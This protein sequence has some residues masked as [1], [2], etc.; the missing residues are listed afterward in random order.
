MKVEDPKTYYCMSA[1]IIEKSTEEP[2]YAFKGM[3]ERV[4]VLERRKCIEKYEVCL[5]QFLQ[6]ESLLVDL[7]QKLIELRVTSEEINTLKVEVEKRKSKSLVIYVVVKYQIFK[8]YF[9]FF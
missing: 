4:L 2:N 1:D 9:K 3:Q 8:K 6:V 5:M 7:K